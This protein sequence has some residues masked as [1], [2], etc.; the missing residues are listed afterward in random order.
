MR[1]VLADLALESQAAT[2]L[3]MELG[4]AFERADADPLAAAW[5][6]I[7]TP[8][9]KFWVCKRTIEATG[10]AMEVWGGNGY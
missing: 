3:M 1:N 8:A 2:L 4:S 5:K 7:V 6:R 10:E 9:A